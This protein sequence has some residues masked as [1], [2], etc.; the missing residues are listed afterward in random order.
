MR[1]PRIIILI[2]IYTS[3]FFFLLFHFSIIKL[4]YYANDVHFTSAYFV[5]IILV[6]YLGLG[7]G[8]SWLKPDRDFNLDFRF[9]PNLTWTSLF[10]LSSLACTCNSSTRIW[11]DPVWK[12]RNFYTKNTKRKVTFFWPRHFLNRLSIV[13]P[14]WG[15]RQPD[16]LSSFT[17]KSQF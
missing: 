12:T 17:V 1:S 14:W 4:Y 5:N 7:T 3:G 6:R 15:R 9:K 2:F 13:K 8:S 10:D 11:S 16:L